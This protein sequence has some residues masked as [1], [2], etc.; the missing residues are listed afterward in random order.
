[1]RV[2]AWVL[3]SSFPVR[4]ASVPARAMGPIIRMEGLG[5]AVRW[6]DGTFALAQEGCMTLI[7]VKQR[8]KGRVKKEECGKGLRPL[9][10]TA[11]SMPEP[12]P[13]PL[14]SEYF[15]QEHSGT[16]DVVLLAVALRITCR[17]EYKWFVRDA[18]AI[19][20]AG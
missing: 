5:A 9:W 20:C 1:L 7:E 8:G 15:F 19:E 3:H 12:Q 4:Q 11:P 10:R 18:K 16:L 6:T 2:V 13:R 17:S 14:N